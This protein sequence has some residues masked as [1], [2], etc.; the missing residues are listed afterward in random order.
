MMQNAVLKTG[1]TVFVA[2]GTMTNRGNAASS[3]DLSRLTSSMPTDLARLPFFKQLARKRS[4]YTCTTVGAR[5]RLA[6]QSLNVA[7]Q[8]ANARVLRSRQALFS[9]IFLPP[10]LPGS[11]S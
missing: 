7:L 1:Y 3:S 11:V 5:K 10:R 6:F 9:P 4:E 2:Q 8:T